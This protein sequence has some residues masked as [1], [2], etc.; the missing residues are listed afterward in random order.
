MGE[1]DYVAVDSEPVCLSSAMSVVHC[2]RLIVEIVKIFLVQIDKVSKRVVARSEY[3]ATKIIQLSGV[4]KRHAVKK[5]V[6]K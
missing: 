4:G 1:S 2:R 5:T 3:V 6:C